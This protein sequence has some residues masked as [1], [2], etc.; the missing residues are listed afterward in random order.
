M[1]G[2]KGSCNDQG[3]EVYERYNKERICQV[4]ARTYKGRGRPAEKDVAKE[5]LFLVLLNDRAPPSILLPR[6]TKCLQGVVC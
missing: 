4:L 5:V 3:I 2:S 6:E 1:E